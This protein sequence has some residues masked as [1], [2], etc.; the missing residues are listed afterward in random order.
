MPSIEPTHRDLCHW[1]RTDRGCTGGRAPLTPSR[2]S[3]KVLDQ[4]TLGLAK[5][6]KRN[7][8]LFQFTIVGPVVA[9]S[10]VQGARS[11]SAV[12]T[13]GSLLQAPC[14][15]PHNRHALARQVVQGRKLAA[16]MSQQGA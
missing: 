14:Y 2:A 16:E 5:P 8:K 4:A 10:M 9:R 7:Y 3:P 6:I 15:N 1:E 13:P 12:Q 11:K